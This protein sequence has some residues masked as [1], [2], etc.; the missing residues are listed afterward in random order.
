[1]AV[2]DGSELS[3]DGGDGGVWRTGRSTWSGRSVDV[4]ACLGVIGGLNLFWRLR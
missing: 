1:M 4:D 3:E 2:A